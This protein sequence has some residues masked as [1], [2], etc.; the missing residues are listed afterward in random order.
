MNIPLLNPMTLFILVVFAALFNT[1][2]IIVLDKWGVADY[3][4]AKRKK[5]M[6]DRCEFCFCFWLSMVELVVFYFKTNP[7][8]DLWSFCMVFIFALCSAVLSRFVL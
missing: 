2:V 4:T 8:F 6:P 7:V 3:Y 1:G 5:W